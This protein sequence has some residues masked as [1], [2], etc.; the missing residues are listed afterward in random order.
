MNSGFFL[1]LIKVLLFLWI[2]IYTVSYA[3]YEKKGNRTGAVF[4]VLI[5]LAADISAI[6]V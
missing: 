6:F 2:N 4:T 5:L 3:I 1:I